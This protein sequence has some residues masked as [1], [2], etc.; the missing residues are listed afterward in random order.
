MAL[1]VVIGKRFGAAIATAVE[2]AG[3]YGT[4]PWHDF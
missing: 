3:I 1:P 2:N 4:V